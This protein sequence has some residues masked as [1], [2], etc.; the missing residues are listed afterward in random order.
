MRT[1]HIIKNGQSMEVSVDAL[2]RINESG[3][4]VEL[5]IQWY[6][7]HGGTTHEEFVKT[8]PMSNGHSL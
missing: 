1:Y 5:D 2:N 8:H 6:L 7:N 4:S 3:E